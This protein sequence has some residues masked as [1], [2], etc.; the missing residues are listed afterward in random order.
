MTRVFG[1]ALPKAGVGGH[2]RPLGVSNSKAFL[3]P[4]SRRGWKVRDAGRAP[5]RSLRAGPKVF[6]VFGFWLLEGRW[7]KGVQGLWILGA[8]GS[9]VQRCSGSSDLGCFRAAVQGCSGSSD[10]G[11]PKAVS[12]GVQGLRILGARGRCPI[13]EGA[14]RSRR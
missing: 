11:Y 1:S 2:W 14:P 4:R 9:L 8:G 3:A 7:S 12:K 13:A 5:A 10:L 6:R